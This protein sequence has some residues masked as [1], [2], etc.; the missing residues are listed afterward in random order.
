MK[1]TKLQIDGQTFYLND[2]QD[3]DALQQQIVDA[4]SAQAA[5][6]HFST[7]GRGEVS[8]LVTPFLGVRFEVQDR[9]AE[10]VETWEE[11][12]PAIESY[13]AEL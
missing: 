3:V 12:P 4:A 8:V 1:I 2:T 11:H 9:S 10:E 13:L 6:V 7:V 5:F